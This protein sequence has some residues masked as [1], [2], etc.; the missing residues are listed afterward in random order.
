M[1][2]TTKGVLEYDSN[3]F[4]FFGVGRKAKAPHKK[5]QE[6]ESKHSN[7]QII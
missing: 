2:Q 6:Q 1:K 3:I 7:K 4:V 5:Q